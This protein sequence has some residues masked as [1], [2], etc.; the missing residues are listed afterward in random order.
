MNILT[1]VLRRMCAQMQINHFTQ[2][3]SKSSI[4]VTCITAAIIILTTSKIN[5]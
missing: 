5:D 3:Y 1:Y 4:N 2:T